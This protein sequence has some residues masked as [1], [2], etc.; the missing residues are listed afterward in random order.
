MMVI[1]KKL[2]L[3]NFLFAWCSAI[4]WNFSKFLVDKK[5]QPVARY[6]PTTNPEVPRSQLNNTVLE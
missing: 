3:V 2:K 1:L 5:G 6:A 4:K